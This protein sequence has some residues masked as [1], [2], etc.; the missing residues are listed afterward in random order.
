V[1]SREYYVQQSAITDPGEHAAL[2][3]D[4][5]VD[6]QGLC[7]TVRGLVVHHLRGPAVTVPEGRHRELDTCYVL[8]MLDRIVELDD[9]PLQESRPPEDRLVGCCRDFAVLFCSMARHKGI[10]ARVRYGFSTC[11]EDGFN[12]LHVV[13]EC[14]HAMERR[15]V[16]VDPEL[17]EECLL[18][19]ESVTDSCE[20]VEAEFITGT[21]AWRALRDGKT[22]P[23]RFGRAPETE[24]G[25]A[26]ALARSSMQDV[27]ALNK[28]ELLLWSGSEVGDEEAGEADELLLDRAAT[29]AE[30]VDDRL[31][32]LQEI[33]QALPKLGF[34]PPP[35][36]GLSPAEGTSATISLQERRLQA[37]GGT[38]GSKGRRRVEGSKERRASR[39]IVPA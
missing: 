37:A 30:L 31:P 26:G 36:I 13:T 25:G 33:Y 19:Q 11:P 4:L 3:D 35:A 18:A 8:R 21:S 38:L 22:D 1:D 10:P 27:A 5:A 34:P 20:V 32:Q 24:P 6:I 15:W 39:R 14:W 12:Y 23:Q 2:F 16:L 17:G 9:R 29:L 28:A 7:S